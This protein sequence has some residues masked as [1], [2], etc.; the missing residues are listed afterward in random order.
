MVAP[1]QNHVLMTK[2]LLHK[3]YDNLAVLLYHMCLYLCYTFFLLAWQEHFVE[4]AKLSASYF[5]SDSEEMMVRLISMT[6]FPTIKI[7][8]NHVQ[9]LYF[10]F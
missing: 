4:N 1:K 8:G 10:I 9:M 7:K 5:I 6:F 3:F 2:L